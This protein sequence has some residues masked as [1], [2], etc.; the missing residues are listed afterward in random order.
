M[1]TKEFSIEKVHASL[2]P[3]QSDVVHLC[4]YGRVEWTLVD[5]EKKKEYK[6]I[7]EPGD[8]L[9]MRGFTLHET[10]PLSVRGSLIF[11]NLSYE[12]FPDYLTDSFKSEEEAQEF[13]KQQKAG[14]LEELKNR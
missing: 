1:Q 4:C 13:Y 2:H 11:M 14:F 10:K 8:V 6:V 5:S 9:Y 3:D 7:L 12:E